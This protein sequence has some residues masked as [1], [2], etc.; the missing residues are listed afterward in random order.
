M[1]I[2]QTTMCDFSDNIARLLFEKD[3]EDIRFFAEHR[4]SS[5]SDSVEG[6]VIERLK[7]K[8]Y[9]VNDWELF[10]AL[11][12]WECNTFV[13]SHLYTKTGIF[14]VYQ[15][16]LKTHLCA[17]C[18]ENKIPYQIFQEV[19]SIYHWKSTRRYAAEYS[20]PLSI[21][22]KNNLDKEVEFNNY[23]DV[24]TPINSSIISVGLFLHDLIDID[25]LIIDK[26]FLER[27]EQIDLRHNYA[28]IVENNLRRNLVETLFYSVQSDKKLAKL[29]F[30]A[31]ETFV[32]STFNQKVESI[33]APLTSILGFCHHEFGHLL[34]MQLVKH[35]FSPDLNIVFA[36]FM[37]DRKTGQLHIE[38]TMSSLVGQWSKWR[39]IIAPPDDLCNMVF[40]LV[41]GLQDGREDD[42]HYYYK[43]LPNLNCQSFLED[44]VKLR[45]ICASLDADTIDT[46]LRERAV[47]YGFAGYVNEEGLWHVLGPAR[48]INTIVCDLDIPPSSV[49]QLTDN[50]NGSIGVKPNQTAQTSSPQ[51]T[52]L[53]NSDGS[54]SA[55]WPLPSDFFEPEYRDHSCP[56]EE[57]I[58]GF[59]SHKDLK[60]DFSLA[61]LKSKDEND[62]RGKQIWLDYVHLRDNFTVLINNIAQQGYIKNTDEEKLALAHALT[63]R[64][65]IK[66]KK[67]CWEKPSLTK[68]TDD[69]FNGICFLTQKLHGGKYGSITRVFN[70]VLKDGE[71]RIPCASYADNAN[72]NFKEIVESFV[73]SV[74]ALK[75]I[76]IESPKPKA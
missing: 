52:A 17:Y 13:N 24:C 37:N 41:L 73:N 58:H 26:E 43:K 6:V 48:D 16:A 64:R 45:N 12:I 22:F 54:K 50:G 21:S 2:H 68:S 29:I 65:V 60:V 18:E 11:A 14:A 4:F 32:P 40:A 1:T 9:S 38:G 59:L 44:A 30:E 36:D 39:W 63:G 53:I 70:G 67:V 35:E 42:Y 56:K 15:D 62:T 23:W 72:P 57:Y 7:S 19:E 31:L 47:N 55:G 49:L 5:Y 76:Y 61:P 8:G 33:I 71:S 34:P 27:I 51:K 66:V 10:L 20:S 3:F 46:Y 69:G 75:V 25:A 74:K 28:E